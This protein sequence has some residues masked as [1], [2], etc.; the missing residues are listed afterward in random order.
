M[1]F[2]ENIINQDA[3]YGNALNPRHFVGYDI[4]VIF[5]GGG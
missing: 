5:Y 1:D 2:T 3:G 4:L